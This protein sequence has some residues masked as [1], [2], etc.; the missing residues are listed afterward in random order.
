MPAIR[1]ASITK[2]GDESNVVVVDGSI[3]DPPAGEV[4]VAVEY[5]GFSGAD[6]NMRR[7][8]Y[9]FQK[10]A[11]LTPGYCLIGRVQVNGPGCTRFQPGDRVA[12]LSIYGAEAQL[13]NLPEKYL[14]PV[15]AGIDLAQATAL[16]LDWNTAYGMLTHAARVRAGQKIFVHGLSGAV[17]YALL[18]LAKLKSAQVFG[19]A[20]PK[21]HAALIE[22]GATPFD[23]SD[24]KWIGAMRDSGGV[25]AAF[26][27]LGFESFDESYSIL[28]RGGVLVAYGMNLPAL[29]GAAPRPILPAFIKLL[30]K[31]LAFWSGKKAVFYGINR[32][33]KNFAPDLQTLFDLLKTGKISVPIK[34]VYP[35][36]DIQ[37]AHRQWGKGAGMGSIVIKIQE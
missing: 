27:A 3:S 25:D 17:G 12:S 8:T 4:Q 10:K 37:N 24:K 32:A 34:A 11:P 1:H 35:L 14:V 26:D 6:I 20:S 16:I 7:G 29:S 30:A 13:I 36:E 19:T 33:S 21:N 23:Y 5:S 28:H 18:T 31:N 9:P 2:Y 22:R 15:P